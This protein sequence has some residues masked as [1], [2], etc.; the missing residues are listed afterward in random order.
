MTF[1][2]FLAALRRHPISLV[3]TALLVTV[4]A[5][6]LGVSVPLALA[7]WVVGSLAC[8]RVWLV[9]EP[10]ALARLGCRQPNRRECERLE[11]LLASAPVE[12]CIQ[13]VDAPQP[14]LGTGLRHLVVS[15][16]L[17][18]VLDD[19]ALVGLLTQASYQVGSASLPGELVMWLG[20]LPVVGMWYLGRWVGV[21]GRVLAIVVGAGLV[22]PL[23][24]CPSG[25]TRWVGRLFGA[26][27]V[28]L[29]GSALL[30]SRH[31]AP[32]LGLLLAWAVVPGL[33]ALV[34]WERRRAE[35]RADAATL[36]AG[37]GWHLLEALETLAWSDALV[38][39]AG[40]L[41]LLSTRGAAI[42]DRADHIW[43]AP[44]GAEVGPTSA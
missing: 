28:A 22:L 1:A 43:R 11:P 6:L 2:L 14:W 10:F 3:C 35:R 41:G 29:L 7:A 21:L 27:F 13:V 15:R 39:P 32:G 17:L 26:M 12:V 42:S 38:A 8:L 5:G 40:P 31:A 37:L 30:A 25:W 36:E 19:R 18:D 44:A 16:A 20:N 24:V 34:G 4:S 9:V 23:L 33:G